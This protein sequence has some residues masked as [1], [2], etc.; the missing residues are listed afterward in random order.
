MSKFDTILPPIGSKIDTILGSMVS[1]IEHFKIKEFKIKE[2]KIN[3][4]KNKKAPASKL[5]KKQSLNISV[6]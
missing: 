5:I 6:K 2:F 4:Y 1:K 3:I